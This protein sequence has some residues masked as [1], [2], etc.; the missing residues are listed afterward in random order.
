[1]GKPSRGFELRLIPA[2]G[3]LDDNEARKPRI[4]M[5]RRLAVSGH[6]W[7][8]W[9]SWRPLVATVR[10]APPT[11]AERLEAL[12]IRPARSQGLRGYLTAQRLAR[13]LSARPNSYR[14]VRAG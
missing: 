4:A 2:P 5:I 8:G 1:M 10:P 13:R 11:E 3:Q 14:R 6:R 12:R 7:I 9:R